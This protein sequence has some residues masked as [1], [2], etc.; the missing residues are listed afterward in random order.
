MP[1]KDTYRRFE[2]HS[3]MVLVYNH[4]WEGMGEGRQAA[5]LIMFL[6]M[7]SC[8][9]AECR[10]GRDLTVAELPMYCMTV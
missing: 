7:L 1:K 8:Q 6:K 2:I 9:Q 4:V 3:R 10:T 5:V